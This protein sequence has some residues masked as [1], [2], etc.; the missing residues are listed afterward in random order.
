VLL[1]V[2]AGLTVNYARGASAGFT[3]DWVHQNS[4]GITRF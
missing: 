1:S 4:S 3:L 2:Y